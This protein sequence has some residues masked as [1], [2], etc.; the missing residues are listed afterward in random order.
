MEWFL[1]AVVVAV[2]GLGAVVASGRLG[3]LPEAVRDAPVPA[4]PEGDLSADDLRGVQFQVVARGYSMA[5]VDEV[6]ARVEDQL[7]RGVR[8]D[9]AAEGWEPPAPARVPDNPPPSAIMTPDEFSQQSERENDGSN[10]APH[11]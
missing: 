6:L 2:L 11:G 4:L 5:Q 10:E 1:W 7:R 8:L 9:S 3:S